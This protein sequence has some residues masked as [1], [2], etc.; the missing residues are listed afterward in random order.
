MIKVNVVSN[1]NLWKRYLKRPADHINRNIKK[2]NK[3]N[4]LYKKKILICTILLSGNRE[5]KKLN[6]QFRNKNK[7]TD[8]L[9]FPFYEKREMKLKLKKKKE[10]YLGD[11]IISI[12]KIKNK[13]DKKNI[14]E[15]LKKLFIHGLTHLLGYRHE[16]DKE[17][18]VMNKVEKTFYNYMK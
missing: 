8:V 3:K 2:L 17:F 7:S 12:N 14:E 16:K 4:K 5:I 10:I 15:K 9:S 1:N 6:K 11:I 18:Y 13:K